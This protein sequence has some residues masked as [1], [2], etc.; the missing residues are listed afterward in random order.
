M[1]KLRLTIATT[2]YDH[3]RD[4]RLGTVQAEGIDTMIVTGTA[5][6]VCCESTARDA[7]MMGYRVFFLE[8]ANAA[9][10]DAEHNATL[11]SMARGFADAPLF[12]L[13]PLENRPATR[14]WSRPASG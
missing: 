14:R 8:D 11:T 5:T 9:L 13:T 7:F 12:C 2:D 10:N 4:F 1:S 6:N 3:F